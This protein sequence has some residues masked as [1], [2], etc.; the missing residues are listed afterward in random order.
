MM[1]HINIFQFNA[2]EIYE[3]IRGDRG[4]LKPNKNSLL[5]VGIYPQSSYFNHSCHPTSAR[6]N[7]GKK[8]IVK[9]L[10]PVAPGQEVSENYGPVFYFNNKQDRQRQLN[11][12]YWFSCE[13]KPCR[14]DW[15][16]LKEN[17]KVRW[18]D[19]VDTA[20][21]DDLKT[22]YDCGAAMMDDGQTKEAE[23]SLTDYI[24]Q[25]YGLVDP[26]LEVLIRAEDKLRTCC[27]NMGTVVFQDMMLKTN[28]AEKSN[29]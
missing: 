13:C 24:N 25:M 11:S 23:E 6:Y 28:P 29:N 22:L 27:N 9:S 4:R 7:I 21:L 18:R 8:M 10:A 20:S 19:M 12:R 3:L 26:P 17:I 15:P 5:G 16:L 1:R 2:H 14:E